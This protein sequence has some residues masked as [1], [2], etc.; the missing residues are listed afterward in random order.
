[1]KET[2]I[3]PKNEAMYIEECFYP[4]RFRPPLA[5]PLSSPRRAVG[6]CDAMKD[7]FFGTFAHGGIESI[8][9]DSIELDLRI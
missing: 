3:W 2:G 4:V 6:K 5:I 9:K 1:M 7:T 8:P